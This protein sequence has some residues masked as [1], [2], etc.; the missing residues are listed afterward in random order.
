MLIIGA[1]ISL[2]GLL[3]AFEVIRGIRIARRLDRLAKSGLSHRQMIAR[4]MI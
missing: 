1:A 2:I 4:G 3:A